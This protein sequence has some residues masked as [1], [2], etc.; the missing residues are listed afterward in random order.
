NRD[1]RFDF[2]EDVNVIAYATD[3]QLHATFGA[4][5]ATD[6]AIK[7]LLQFFI[8]KWDAILRTENDVIKQIRECRR[9]LSNSRNVAPS[10]LTDSVETKNQGL[11][12]LATR[13]RPSGAERSYSMFHV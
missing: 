4:D 7:F 6:V 2:G 12:A 3:F 13:R 5:D 10:G 1:R 9:H 11:A 8:D